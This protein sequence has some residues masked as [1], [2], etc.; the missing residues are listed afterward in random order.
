MTDARLPSRGKKQADPCK[1]VEGRRCA[2]MP[3]V[4][5]WSLAALGETPTGR[6]RVTRVAVG[7]L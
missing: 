2:D 1:Y 5:W 4:G 3:A 6:S 7:A